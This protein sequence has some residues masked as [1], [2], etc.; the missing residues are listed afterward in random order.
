MA[1]EARDLRSM[2]IEARDLRSEV[3]A[4]DPCPLTSD[5]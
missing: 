4:F 3:G 1:I 5:L 2:A